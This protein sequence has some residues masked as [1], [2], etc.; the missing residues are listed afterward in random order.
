MHIFTRV[1]LIMM[2]HREY[3]VVKIDINYSIK[4]ALV[5]RSGHTRFNR[6]FAHAN[7]RF[8]FSS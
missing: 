4:L 8:I 2:C 5:D 3:F 1:K 7:M 6:L